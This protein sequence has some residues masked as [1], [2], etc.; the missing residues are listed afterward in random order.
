M[1]MM[2]R[3]A[4]LLLTLSLAVSAE[5]I[6]AMGPNAGSYNSF[7]DQR[8]SSDAMQ[9]AGRVNAAITPL[10]TPNCPQ[11]PLF[12]NETAANAMLV[13][14][15]DNAKI[16][17]AP[18]FFT[19]VYEAYGD[20]AIM[21]FIAHELGHAL[22]ETRPADWVKRSWAPELRA[23]AWAACILAKANL[24]QR[25]L[26]D[27]LTAFAKYPSPAHPAWSNRLPAVR[28]G[29]TQCGGDGTKFDQSANG[30]KRP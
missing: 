28:I 22:D 2:Q 11:L 30:G 6:C 20:G 23:D 16:V 19:T 26:A 24:S 13:A 12:R 4:G 7:S 9:L 3:V 27:A 29:F 18:K 21:A 8:P 17:Y 1:A 14:G 25:D 10:C 15:Q 5:T